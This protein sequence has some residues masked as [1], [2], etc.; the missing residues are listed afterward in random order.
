MK[1]QFCNQELPDGAKFCH[2]CYRQIVCLG[3]GELLIENSSICVYCGKE[4]K[5]PSVQPNVNHIKY[6][7]TENGKSFEASFSDETAGNVVDVF[8]RFLPI[9]RNSDIQQMFYNFRKRRM[10]K[11]KK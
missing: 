10:Q 7:E 3:C 5:M 2:K 1:C 6:S 8:A 4:I 11:Q 9:K